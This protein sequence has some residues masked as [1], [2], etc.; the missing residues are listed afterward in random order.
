M[1][2]CL[3]PLEIFFVEIPHPIDPPQGLGQGEREVPGVPHVTPLKWKR[4]K[5]RLFCVKLPFCH[6]P[7]F[8]V[9]C[10]VMPL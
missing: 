6:A 4:K 2:G 1:D 10:A 8:V 5:G 9:F 3:P 7:L